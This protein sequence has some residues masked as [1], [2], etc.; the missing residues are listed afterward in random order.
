MIAVS[1]Y[2]GGLHSKVLSSDVSQWW[3]ERAQHLIDCGRAEDAL[4]LF[5]EF[6]EDS[7]GTLGF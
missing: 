2:F 7:A 1:E 4:S 3:R 6:G 5:L